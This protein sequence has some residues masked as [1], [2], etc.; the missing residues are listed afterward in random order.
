M[1]KLLTGLLALVFASQVESAPDIERIKELSNEAYRGEFSSPNEDTKKTY[2]TL[3]AKVNNQPLNSNWIVVATSPEY[4]DG[5]VG[6]L[7]Y[8]SDGIN[9]GYV[10][11]DSTNTPA[12]DGVST[13]SDLWAYD[14]QNDE[15]FP[16]DKSFTYDDPGN[17]GPLAES[18]NLNSNSRISDIEISSEGINVTFS[19]LAMNKYTTVESSTNLIDQVFTEETNFNSTASVYVF[20]DNTPLPQKYFRIKQENL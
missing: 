13:I 18:T 2:W 14:A 9:S 10:Y 16:L 15:I 5:L 6:A 7:T 1:K 3:D 20:T 12:I 4:N 8:I 11:G 17:L 19:D